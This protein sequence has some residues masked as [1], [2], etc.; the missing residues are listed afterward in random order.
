VAKKRVAFLA[1][2]LTRGGGVTR[3]IRTVLQ[4]IDR[5]NP[6]LEVVV[7]TDEESLRYDNLEVVVLRTKPGI[8]SDNLS[9]C[10]TLVKHRFDAVVYPKTLIPFTH[11]FFPFRKVIVA[12]DLVDYDPTITEF[13]F[14]DS[15]YFKLAFPVSLLFA[16]RCFA[17]SEATRRDIQSRFRWFDRPMPLFSG[18]VDE[19]FRRDPTA[20]PPANADLDVPFVFYCGSLSPRKNMLRTMQ[21]FHRIKDR[22]PHRFYVCS[23]VSWNDADVL[24]YIREHLADRVFLLGPA[25]TEELVALY[26]RADAFLFPS[27]YEGFGLPILEA[28]ACGCPL[29]TSDRTSCPEVAG[30][31]AVIVDPERVDAIADGILRIVSSPELREGLRQKGYQNVQRYSWQRTAEAVLSELQAT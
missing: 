28:Q 17:S 4:E 6:A 26:S 20:R 11:F 30:A 27:L 13:S 7:I 1:R 22:I 3:F 8:F 29:L 12:Y 18:A 5:Q 19:R 2:G 10:A 16:S 14:R 23:G 9:L 21:A 15:L 25:D 31:G 24:A